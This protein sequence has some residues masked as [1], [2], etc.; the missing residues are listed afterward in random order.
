MKKLKILSIFFCL[1][2]LLSGCSAQNITPQYNPSETRSSPDF[3]LLGAKSWMMKP[4]E[5]SKNAVSKSQTSTKASIT[6]QKRK[7]LNS[8]MSSQA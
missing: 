2:F 4:P 5:K 1:I 7:S 6:P 3:R 8:A